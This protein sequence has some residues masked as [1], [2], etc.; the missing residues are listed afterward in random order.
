MRDLNRWH[1][2]IWTNE[3]K[4]LTPKTHLSVP[5]LAIYILC[6][7]LNNLFCGGSE[8][9]A[10]VDAISVELSTVHCLHLEIWKHK[11]AVF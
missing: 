2:V 11:K 7:Y 9:D 8:G 5:Y 1:A 10:A 6:N 3:N 4:I